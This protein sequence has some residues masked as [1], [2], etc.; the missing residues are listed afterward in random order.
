[1]TDVII[2]VIFCLI[3]TYSNSSLFGLFVWNW[4]YKMYCK[5]QKSRFLEL[6]TLVYLQTKIQ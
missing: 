4:Y 5:I 2:E 6:K 3:F 1:M